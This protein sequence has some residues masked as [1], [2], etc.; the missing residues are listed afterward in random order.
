MIS[1]DPLAGLIARVRHTYPDW[2]GFDH[3]AFVDV[4]IDYKQYAVNL[5]ATTLKQDALR[6]LIDAG[7]FDEVVDQ[8][9]RLGQATNLLSQSRPKQGDM[10]ILFEDNL[11]VPAFAEAMHDLLFGDGPDRFGRYLQFVNSRNLPNK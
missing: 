11:D 6:G 3:Q 7:D 8:L 2:S 9:K 1:T 5:A 4:E 10:N